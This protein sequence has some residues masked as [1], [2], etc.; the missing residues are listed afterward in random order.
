MASEVPQFVKQLGKTFRK[1]G[2]GLDNFGTVLQMKNGYTER[3]VPSTRV[4]PFKGKTFTYGLHNFVASSASVVGDVAVGEMSSVWYGA[5]I[6]GDRGKVSVGTNTSI[7]DNA[8]VSAHGKHSAVIGNDVVISPGAVV[9]GATI[10]DGTMIGMGAI[11]QAG[12]KIGNDCFIDGGC[13]VPANTVIPSGQLWTGNPARRLRD[14]T[15][16]EMTYIR[17]T[18]LEYGRLSQVHFEQHL[19]TPEQLEEE[20]ELRLFK[21]EKGLKDDENLPQT[22]ADVIQ[23][24][25]LTDPIESQ[26]LFREHEYNNAEEEKIKEIDEVKADKIET[27]RYYALARM[28]RVGGALLQLSQTK[29]GKGAQ[30]ISDLDALDGEGATM[31]KEF[32]QKIAQVEAS[33]DAEGKK[34]LIEVLGSFNPASDNLEPEEITAAAEE[35]YKAL[36]SHSKFFITSGQ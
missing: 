3:L 21:L 8:I 14:L 31:A 34:Q 33:N 9:R 16:E 18:A 5:T 11:V 36:V 10:G 20:A 19:K 35:T 2:R 17:S 4:V 23:Y 7:L 27:E 12:A 28:R 13:V 29:P 24:Y 30:V 26:G 25:K 22:S 15:N 32:I 6:K 1:I